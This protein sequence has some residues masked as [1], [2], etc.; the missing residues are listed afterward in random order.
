MDAKTVGRWVVV[1]VLAWLTWTVVRSPLD[2]TLAN[3]F[4]HLPNLVFHEAGHI[5][6]LP[7][8]RFMTVLGG[9][10]LQILVPIVCAVALFH[11][12][13]PRLQLAKTITANHWN[14]WACTVLLLLGLLTA[15]LSLPEQQ[16]FLYFQF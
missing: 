4:L 5:L 6:F 11:W 10:L 8:G 3:S 9:S 16:M 13:E 2:S 12:L 15:A 7:F 1:A 14:P